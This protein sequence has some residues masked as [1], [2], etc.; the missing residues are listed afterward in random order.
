MTIHLL[1]LF[2]RHKTAHHNSRR[3]DPGC[4]RLNQIFC[5]VN[6]EIGSRCPLLKIEACAS[7]RVKNIITELESTCQAHFLPIELGFAAKTAHIEPLFRF[8]C[9]KSKNIFFNLHTLLKYCN[10]FLLAL[11]SNFCYNIAYVTGEK[12][13]FFRKADFFSFLG[14]EKREA[15]AKTEKTAVSGKSNPPQQAPRRATPGGN[16]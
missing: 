12:E 11:F 3:K 6:C 2:W 13:R 10:K 4:G 5:S 1:Y 8:P 15:V 16:T 9:S 14:R 7:I